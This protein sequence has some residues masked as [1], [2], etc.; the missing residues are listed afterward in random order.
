F[1]PYCIEMFCVARIVGEGDKQS[2]DAAVVHGV[3][4]GYFFLELLLR[5]SDDEII[6]SVVRHFLN[7][8]ND[9]GHEVAVQARNND[10]DCISLLSAKVTCESIL[11]VAHFTGRLD[12]AL[13]CIFS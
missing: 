12:D 5:L 1:F 3:N 8:S 9:G 13:F 4:T 6:S 10:P 11:L 7:S 2:I